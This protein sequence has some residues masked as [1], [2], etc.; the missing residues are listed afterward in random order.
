[1]KNQIDTNLINFT[2]YKDKL[3]AFFSSKI[4]KIFQNK[5]KNLYLRYYLNKL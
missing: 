2:K 3:T 4:K 1:M 5:S